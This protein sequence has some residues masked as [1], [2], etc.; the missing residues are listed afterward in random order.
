MVPSMSRSDAGSFET[1]YSSDRPVQ[2]VYKC[3][4]WSIS[5]HL[6]VMG[7]E[8]GLSRLDGDASL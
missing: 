4:S 5:L 3:C 2:V 1:I 6:G 7:A 8:G